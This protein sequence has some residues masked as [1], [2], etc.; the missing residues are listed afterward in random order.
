LADE[1]IRLRYDGVYED[2]DGL[3]AALDEDDGPDEA[4]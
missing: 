1:E 4:A 2:L 3:L